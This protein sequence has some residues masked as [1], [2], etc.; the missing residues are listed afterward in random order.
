MKDEVMVDIEK[1]SP[2][3]VSVI[4]RR[5]TDANSVVALVQ[6]TGGN[7]ARTIDFG[8]VTVKSD[9]VAVAAGAQFGR[10]LVEL[11]Q[12]AAN[13]AAG[14]SLLD[15]ADAGLSKIETTLGRLE[16]LAD[17]A[18]LARVER[19]DGSAATPAE[20]SSQE[21]AVLNSEF[22]DL[23]D[24]IDDVASS[25]QFNGIGLLAGDSDAGGSPL[26]LTFRSGGSADKA[27]S[28]TLADSGA[29]AL[30]AALPTADLMS[31]ASANA[32]VTAVAEAQGN[33]ADTRAAVRG[34]R[35][36]L[37]SVETAAGEMS[38]IVEN[39][40]EMRTSPETVVDLSRVVALQV[41]EEGGVNLSDG[42]QKLLQD[43]LLRMSVATSNG[44][45]ASGGDAVE[46]F[47][48]KTA[49]APA[50][51]DTADIS[52]ASSEGRSDSSD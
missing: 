6:Q 40:R 8:G 7:P 11:R 31:Q 1:T 13:A 30:S 33:V 20:L 49:G 43:V 14:A 26:E 16:V 12:S 27:V 18:S 37:N 50:A 38:A 25:T 45:P 19:D 28:V 3:N 9:R 22:D 41:S 36:Q 29:A 23:L 17:T 4:D 10:Q 51:A 47:G 5:T 35:A 44:G 34:A 21:R 15:V 24:E 39:V 32:A 52:F 42:A 2:A 46:E 48:G